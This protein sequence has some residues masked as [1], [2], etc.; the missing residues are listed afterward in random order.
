[1]KF[2]KKMKIFGKKNFKN[3]FFDSFS[4][5]EA[6][7]KIRNTDKK[8]IKIHQ[9]EHILGKVPLLVH[10]GGGGNSRAPKRGGPHLRPKAAQFWAPPSVCFWYLP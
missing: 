10:C 7:R 9:L 3:F 8:N 1:M 4:F 6:P 5:S 2:E